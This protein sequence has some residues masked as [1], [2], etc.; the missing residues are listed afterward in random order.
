MIIDNALSKFKKSAKEEPATTTSVFKLLRG[1]GGCLNPPCR[2]HSHALR[3]VLTRAGSVQPMP[4]CLRAL[5]TGFAFES[6]Q[7]ICS[8]LR[9]LIISEVPAIGGQNA[10]HQKWAQ[11]HAL[12][13]F[14]G[15]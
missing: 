9:F 15:G 2:P 10:N 11:A 7:V 3:D 12:L 8:A 1:Y 13:G 5:L 14:W 4:R 6:L